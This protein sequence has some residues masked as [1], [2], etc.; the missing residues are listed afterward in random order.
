MEHAKRWVIRNQK[1]SKMKLT[2][3]NT[4]GRAGGLYLSSDEQ[5][6]LTGIVDG[7]DKGD[8]RVDSC[9]KDRSRS[10]EN[11]EEESKENEE[12]EGEASFW[13]FGET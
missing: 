13:V 4:L 3:F 6:S 8:F 12:V 7:V 10:F 2:N 11:R 9:R 1:V 5:V